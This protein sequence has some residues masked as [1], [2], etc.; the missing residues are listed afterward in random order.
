MFDFT[1]L[2]KYLL[3]GLAV[4]VAA[5]VLPQRGLKLQEIVL[6]ALTAAATFAVLDQF[7]PSVASG[8]RFGA[9]FA[10]GTQLV[11]GSSN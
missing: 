1:D 11:G 2:F 3:E 9:G 7:S 5:Y 8:S 4:A 6:V 10:T